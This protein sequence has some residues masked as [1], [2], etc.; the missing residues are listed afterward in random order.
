MLNSRVLVIGS[1]NMDLVCNVEKFPEP[2]ETLFGNKFQMIPGGKGANQ[3]V[4]IGKLGGEVLFIGKLG[5]DA[6]RQKLMDS[7]VSNG[8]D[9]SNILIDEKTSSGTALITVDSTGENKIIVISGSNM[10]LL[11]SDIS[12]NKEL[13]KNVKIVLAQLEIPM[14]SIVESARIAKQEDKNLFSIRL[15][16]KSYLLNY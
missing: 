14:A 11:P 3:A 2:G 15:L 8:V 4:S 13:F 7:L 6:F 5:N 1:A 10:N 16:L 12:S 9:V